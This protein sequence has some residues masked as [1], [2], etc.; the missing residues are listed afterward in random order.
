M[1]SSLIRHGCF[2]ILDDGW[3][4]LDRGHDGDHLPYVP[5]EYL[6]LPLI[7]PLDVLGLTLRPRPVCPLCGTRCTLISYDH[8]GVIYREFEGEGSVECE[9]RFGPCGCRGREIVTAVHDA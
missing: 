4:E 7:T 6:P 5:G 9:W 1:Y 2:R 3:C 8:P